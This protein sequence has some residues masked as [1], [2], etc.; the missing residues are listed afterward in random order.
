M[1]VSAGNG[2]FRVRAIAGTHVVLMAMNCPEARCDG[3]LGFA[4]SVKAAGDPGPARWLPSQKVFKSVVPDPTKPDPAHPGHR[5]VFSSEKHPVQSFLWS[6]YEAEPDTEYEYTVV[7]MYGTPGR[8]EP[9]A[10][11]T[12]RIRT[13]VPQADGHGVWFNRG[14]I[15]SQ[16]FAAKFGNKAPSNIDDPK[17]P[18]VVWL[19]RGLLEACLAYIRETPAGDGLRVAAYEFTYAPVIAELKAA[20]DRGVDVRIVYHDTSDAS[21]A[22]A[23]ANEKAI[24]AAQ[25][26]AKIGRRRVLFPRAHTKIPHNK[27]I[28]RLSGGSKPSAVWTGSTNFTDS[29]F[30]GQT[31]VGHVIE[32]PAAAGDYLEYWKA[33]T[34][35]PLQDDARTKAV[36]LTPDPPKLPGANSTTLVFSPRPES[37]LLSWYGDRIEDATG[38]VMFTAAFGVTEQLVA[39]LAKERDI[40]RFILLEKPLSEKLKGR[41][42]AD[43]D[44]VL[45]YGIPLGQAYVF[46]NGQPV[47]R[48]PIAEFELDKWL[49]KEDHF[50]HDGFVFFVHTKFLLIDPL[51]ED[52]LVCSGSANFSPD[53]LLHNDENML[54]IRGNRRVADI[55]LTE[56]DRIFRHFYCRDI[57]N[58]LAAKKVGSAKPFLDET[59]SWTASYFKSGTFKSRRREMFF[60]TPPRTWAENA[61]DRA[62]P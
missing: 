2:D 23:S 3:L 57:I 53:S 61:A 62:G 60:A 55:Y 43:R 24:A 22:D 46:K 8:L 47:K 51:S 25:L 45:S 34:K 29:G 58:E 27:F 48:A 56:F 28:V 16:S 37:K 11:T 13:E 20:L 36:A 40:L 21:G 1:R 12:F 59:S 5:P 6:D 15:A 31:N 7:A 35:D 9:K 19:S 50:R 10:R 30:L 26:P 42:D 39:P 32:N 49:L 18:E 33:L 44:V 14:A 52:P 54:L 38:T 17:D 41:L 4:I